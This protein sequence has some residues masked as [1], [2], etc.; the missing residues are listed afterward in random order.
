VFER[1]HESYVLRM[2]KG[3]PGIYQLDELCSFV[4]RE[5]ARFIAQLKVE[6]DSILRDVDSPV[7]RI[8]VTCWVGPHDH[9]SNDR[10]PVA[11]AGLSAECVGSKGLFSNAGQ[12]IGRVNRNNTFSRL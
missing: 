1:I 2:L 11:I 12:D 3:S 10:R 7:H 5:A 9:Y 6:V 8:R 4:A